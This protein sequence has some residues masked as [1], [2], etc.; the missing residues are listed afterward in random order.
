MRVYMTCVE[1][2]LHSVIDVGLYFTNWNL[3][4]KCAYANAHVGVS[5]VRTG[6]Y[7]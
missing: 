3:T 4:H 5:L 7:F 6:V 2:L 1:L